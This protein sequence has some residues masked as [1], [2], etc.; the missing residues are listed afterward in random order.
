ML[1]IVQRNFC[2]SLL[3]KIG[4]HYHYL[5]HVTTFLIDGISYTVISTMLAVW[6]FHIQ[7]YR[8]AMGHR[9]FL[10]ELN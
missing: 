10:M 3:D 8:F 1:A 5:I 2:I 6:A 7:A 4:I 9:G